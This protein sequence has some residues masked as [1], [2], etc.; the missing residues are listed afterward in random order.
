[1]QVTKDMVGMFTIKDG[2][3]ILTKCF[4]AH[5]NLHW[6]LI[7]PNSPGIVSVEPLEGGISFI[8]E[9]KRPLKCL[10]VIKSP[11]WGISVIFI[12]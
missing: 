1:M 7:Y 12:F 3:V 11:L 2:K 9:R 4:I 5:S 10:M 8:I 6:E